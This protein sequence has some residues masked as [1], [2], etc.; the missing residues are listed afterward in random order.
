MRSRIILM[1][2]NTFGF[3]MLNVVRCRGRWCIMGE[4]HS[5]ITTKISLQWASV[6]FCWRHLSTF[7]GEELCIYLF[8]KDSK[9]KNCLQLQPINVLLNKERALFKWIPIH[10]FALMRPTTNWVYQL[11]ISNCVQHLFWSRASNTEREITLWNTYV[12]WKTPCC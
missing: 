11:H 3:W 6:L 8:L 5:W 10:I 7:T 2:L 1:L 4:V 9:W 12:A